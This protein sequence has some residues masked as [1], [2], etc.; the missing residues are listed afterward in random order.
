[1]MS[2]IEAGLSTC[3][4][5]LGQQ[6]AVCHVGFL[7]GIHFFIHIRLLLKKVDKMQLCNRAK[8]KSDGNRTRKS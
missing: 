6:G 2:K 5:L 4:V 3:A 1:M 7:E 8:I